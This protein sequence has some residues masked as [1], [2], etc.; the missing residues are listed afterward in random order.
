MSE[1][2][3]KAGN[4]ELSLTHLL[5]HSFTLSLDMLNIFCFHVY[6]QKSLSKFHTHTHTHSHSFNLSFTLS[7]DMLNIFCFHV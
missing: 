1:R 3:T 4:Q 7:L 5:T 2:H 6:A